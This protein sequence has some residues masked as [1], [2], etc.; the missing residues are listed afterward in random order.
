MSLVLTPEQ[1][2]LRGIVRG[3][4]A[5][6]SPSTEVRRLMET[7]DG[8]DRAVWAIAAGE[9]GLQGLALPEEYGGGDAGIVEQVLVS[10]EAG[11]AVYAAPYL[12]TTLAA[13]AIL[14]ADDGAAAKDLLP[15]IGDGSVIAALAVTE[16][17]G[18]WEPGAATV[19]A[20]RTARGFA[21]TG[22]K[23]F[24]LD[25]MAADLFVVSARTEAGLALF[26]VR[27]DAAGLTRTALET[28]D[29]TR[30]Q[31]RLEL[32]GVEAR[33]I[34]EDGAAEAVLAGTRD[35]ALT[36]LSAELVGTAQWCLDTTV[37]YAKMRT[38]FGRRIGSFQAVKH[39]LADM[40]LGLESARAAVYEAARV[41]VEDPAALPV[42][43]AAAKAVA[44]DAATFAATETIQLHGGIGFTWEH[45]AH[46][47]YRRAHADALLFGDATR[48]RERLAV[49]LGI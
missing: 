49:L 37:E 3:F 29:R 26:A 5:D 19:R 42:A 33:L 2:D 21:L 8:L 11:R 16:D 30:K 9:L 39:R 24:V 47:Y 44:S 45:D 25:G 35:L 46:L 40:L 6:R 34:G 4:L 12:G 15:G 31:A 1:E 18:S 22:H 41:A 48:Q 38:Q 23:N 32:A 36:L 27:A 13:D 14:R 28:L 20:E 7:T 43:A 17:D 10:E